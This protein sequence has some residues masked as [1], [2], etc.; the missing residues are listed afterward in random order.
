MT[1]FQ[2]PVNWRIPLQSQFFFRGD[3]RPI[4]FLVSQKCARVP[5]VIAGPDVLYLEFFTSRLC[6]VTLLDGAPILFPKCSRYL[7][8]IEISWS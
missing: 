3:Y 6:L 8:I 1:V 7:G 5:L 2:P 4:I